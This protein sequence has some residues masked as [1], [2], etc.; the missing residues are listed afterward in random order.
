[1]Y[2]ANP[3]AATN[4][5]QMLPMLNSTSLPIDDL[6]DLP[7]GILAPTHQCKRPARS[8]VPSGIPT[9]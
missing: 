8:S 1:V 2:A 6:P 3:T 9:G 7:A 4:P 5:T